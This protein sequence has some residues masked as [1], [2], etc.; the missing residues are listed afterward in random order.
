MKKRL[1]LFQSIFSSDMKEE[2]LL[3]IVLVTAIFCGEGNVLGFLNI[4]DMGSNAGSLFFILYIA[5]SF[6][7]SLPIKYILYGGT[8][9]LYL[10][11]LFSLLGASFIAE[12]IAI[13]SISMLCLNGMILLYS[14]RSQSKTL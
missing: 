12:T 4:F 13:F 5:F 10:M 2:V 14:L 11:T 8:L 9:T 6:L 1:K 3:F 7:F